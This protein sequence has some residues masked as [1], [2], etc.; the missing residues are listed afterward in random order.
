MDY[1]KKNLYHNFLNSRIR[2]PRDVDELFSLLNGIQGYWPIAKYG[3]YKAIVKN[4]SDGI[5]KDYFEFHLK[6]PDG[7]KVSPE[8]E[9]AR[10]SNFL[11]PRLVNSETD[12]QTIS[13]QFEFYFN[14]K[15]PKQILSHLSQDDKR[16]VLREMMKKMKLEEKKNKETLDEEESSEKQK[17]LISE[18]PSELFDFVLEKCLEGSLRDSSIYNLIV[19][20]KTWSMFKPK[21]IKEFKEIENLYN[22]DIEKLA[23][24]LKSPESY[25]LRFQQLNILNLMELIYQKEKWAIYTIN[26]HMHFYRDFAHLLILSKVKSEDLNYQ[27]V[28]LS[29]SNELIVREFQKIGL[30]KMKGKCKEINLNL[31]IFSYVW[32][33]D[34]VAHYRGN[35]Y[36][37][38]GVTFELRKILSCNKVDKLLNFSE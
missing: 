34:L 9:D 23:K 6:V 21:V 33:C 13:H 35:P 29:E 4:W 8:I 18:L 20:K 7:F 25:F 5:V 26:N 16:V 1:L 31:G 12:V 27:S 28:E 15:P 32:L 30:K 19:D 38:Y 17:N 36:E 3:Y 14:E 11:L 10:S 2:K 37:F 24:F 22:K